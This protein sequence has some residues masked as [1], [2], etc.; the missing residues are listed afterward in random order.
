MGAGT[1]E[2][3]VLGAPL[4]PRRGSP[5]GRAQA[6]GARSGL[7]ARAPAPLTRLATAAPGGNAKGAEGG[8]AGSLACSLLSRSNGPARSFGMDAHR[9][10]R[11]TEKLNPARPPA[12]RRQLQ[13]PSPPPPARAAL[14]P[15]GAAAE[16]AALAAARLGPPGLRDA[17]GRRGGGRASANQG[18]RPSRPAR[19]LN[20]LGGRS[21]RMW[22]VGSARLLGESPV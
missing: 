13:P 7:P 16:A 4:Q 3:P 8:D 12:A 22:G 17:C 1:S 9:R 5:P 2:P 11:A 19:G 20:Q 21:A 14:A 15:T 18:A 6:A 10:S